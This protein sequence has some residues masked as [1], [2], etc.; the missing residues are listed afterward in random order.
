MRR[1][2]AKHPHDFSAYLNLG[3]ILMSRLDM[4]GAAGALKQAVHIDPKRPEPHDILGSALQNLGFAT[5]ALQQFQ[6]AVEADPNY[7]NARYD[8]ARALAREGKYEDAVAQFEPVAREFPNSAR[9]QDEYGVLLAQSG[10]L[11][12]ALKEF[13]A[14]LAIDPSYEDARKNREEIA[15]EIAGQHPPR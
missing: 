5:E 4:Q 6:L 9:I 3:A 11:A 14:A 7:I 15:K 2:L 10:R 1:R 8:L 12:E 13:D